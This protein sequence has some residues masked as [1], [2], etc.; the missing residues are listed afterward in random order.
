MALKFIVIV[1]PLDVYYMHVTSGML[2]I[3]LCAHL[4][5]VSCDLL[6]AS[7]INLVR[8]RPINYAFYAGYKWRIFANVQVQLN[9]FF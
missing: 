5:F 8:F 4:F 3:C 6:G 7:C 1:E 2:C 9:I